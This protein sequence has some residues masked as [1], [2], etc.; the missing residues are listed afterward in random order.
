M[1][2]LVLGGVLVP[3]STYVLAS[4]GRYVLALFPAFYFLGAKCKAHPRLERFLIF[5][6]TFFL[7]LYGIRFMRCAFA[8]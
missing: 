1:S 2:V 3:L 7:A 6:S 5:A 4:M 8:G